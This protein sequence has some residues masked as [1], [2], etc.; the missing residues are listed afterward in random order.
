MLNLDLAGS[1][2]GA[3]N[4]YVNGTSLAP[5]PV[6]GFGNVNDAAIYR[7]GVL[8]G[9]ARSYQ[10][11]FDANLLQPGT[12]VITFTV[13]AGGSNLKWSGTKPVLPSA[14][15]MYDSIEL[16]AGYPPPPRNLTWR[17]GLSGNAWDIS[18]TQNWQSNGV[19]TLFA[20]GDHATFD[21]S[22]SNNLNI[23]LTGVLQPGTVTVNSG[24]NYVFGGA[25]SLAGAMTL[26]K[27]GA[28]TLTINTTNIFLGGTTLV[29]GKIVLGTNFALGTGGL[30]LAGGSLQLLRNAAID[31]ALQVQ[32]GSAVLNNGNNTLNGSWS[33]DGLVT[34][35]I[36]TNN[37]IS[38][39]GPGNDFGGTLS[40]GTSPG[41][42]RFNQGTNTW[43]LSNA[44][45]DAGTLGIIR[46]RFTGSGTLYLGGLAGGPASKLLATDQVVNPGSTNTCVI[47]AANLDTTFAG[48]MADTAHLLALTKIGTGTLTL[49]GT[50]NYSGLTAV[51][52]GTLQVLGQL[53]TTNFIIVSSSA[54]LDLGGTL[55]AGLVQI[56]SG[57]TLTGCGTISGPLVNHG[58]VV[59]VCGAGQKLTI[60][61]S[62]T[63]HGT[64]QLIAGTALEVTGTFVNNGVIDII[65]SE[66]GLPPGIINNGVIIN[67]SSVAVQS[68]DLTGGD[69]TISIMTY[70]NHNYQL[71]RATSL[72][73][74]VW[75]NV[76]LPEPGTG[77]VVQLIDSPAPAVDQL[78][79]RVLVA[80]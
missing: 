6:S 79:Y 16:N 47:G 28:G 12:N 38:V 13:R 9:L 57:G 1:I 51:A 55:T 21:N 70:A 19:A 66:G 60:N 8:G 31:N 75:T 35:T 20:D 27:Y 64:L 67:S 41:A 37:V 48:T 40:L 80:P 53:A 45:V 5:N 26:A 56:N 15:I 69:V 54:T 29:A 7:D 50:N 74:P 71:K 30:N 62:F 76:G 63:N 32:F 78:Y 59:A 11:S 42:L 25:G 22:G 2:Q 24:S 23:A 39:G 18:T 61:G 44:V 52:A 43:G 14:G 46:N 3:F 72:S 65:T 17:G 10:L 49:T 77:G 68:V 4:V 33:G 58:T 34:F 73:L 36:T